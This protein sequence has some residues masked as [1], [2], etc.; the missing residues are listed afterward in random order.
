MNIGALSE[1]AKTQTHEYR[2]HDPDNTIA[3]I[4]PHGGAIEAATA[5]QAFHVAASVEACS[6]WAYCG[7][8]TDSETGAFEQ[9]HRSSTTISED[10]FDLSSKL[11]AAGFD[12]I[13]SFHGFDPEGAVEVYLGGQIE[14]S[15]KQRVAKHIQNQT[16]LY[17]KVAEPNDGLYQMYGGHK[18]ENI[19]NRWSHH[20]GLQ[21]EQ[22]AHARQT[23]G[24]AICEAIIDIFRN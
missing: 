19:T 9:F 18:D 3:T 24:E 7:Y 6:A 20:G 5:K 2:T 22:T 12:H 13:I 21:I 4:A 23:H 8:T 14:R 10:E 15:L 1:R 17:A 16:G 11:R